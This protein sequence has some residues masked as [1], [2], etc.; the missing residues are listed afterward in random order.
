MIKRWV[1]R[2]QPEPEV[3]TKLSEAINVN[4]TLC[5]VLLQRNIKDFIAAKS[6]FRPT[7][8][9]LHDPFLM[10]DMSIAVE[11]LE[12]AMERK[13]KILIYGDYDVDG[14]TSVAMFYDF[15]SSIYP[16]VDF[17]IPDRYMEGYGVSQKSIEWASE[18]GFS[19]IITLDCGIKAMD[20]IQTARQKGIDFIVCDH[21]RPGSELP[22]AVAILDPKREDCAYPY[23]E[24]SGCGVG[25]KFMQAFSSTKGLSE[26]KLF[27]Y[28][29]LLAVSI[30]SDIVP[31]TGENRVMVH[32]GLQRLN[33]DPRPGLRALIRLSG[34]KNELDISG[35]VFGVGPRINAAGRISHAKSS[36]ELLLAKSEA[37]AAHFAQKVDVK[38]DERRSF[39]SNI[40]QEALEMIEKSDNIKSAKSTVLF[41]HDWHKGVIGIVASRCIEKY[42]RPTIILTASNDKATG[43]ARSVPGFD[44]YNAIANCSDLLLQY[45]G[46]R[47]AAGLTMDLS[48][49]VDFQE[50]FEAEVSRNITDEQLIPKIEID[51][52]L[53]LSQITPKF[54]NILRQMGPFGPENMPLVFVAH[55]VRAVK[56]S[57]KILKD[58]HV[59]FTAK[60]DGSTKM[61]DAIG[62]G[63]ATYYKMID[64]GMPFK[65]AFTIEENRYMGNVTLQL[66]VKDLKFN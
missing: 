16:Y 56:D 44:V 63:L 21:H 4:P 19:L 9:M 52:E 45:G 1:Y 13:E 50:K 48:K 60:E 10:K 53:S 5:A 14:T 36:V 61:M 27:G 42:H 35:I 34:Q 22:P 66:N 47:Y 49:V 2:T 43:S 59:K 62:F 32:Y 65:L 23:K 57:T 17:Y 38:N 3:I 46:H 64:S 25:F 24:L 20:P 33:S 6:F 31:V 37:E 58:K 28:L 55:N 29:D 26:E 30:A 18:N 15:V 40:T 7:L 12:A 41:K 54:F 8:D 51:N 39:D 11:R